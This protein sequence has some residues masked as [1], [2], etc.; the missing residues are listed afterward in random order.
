MIVN[1]AYPFMGEKGPSVNPYLWQDGV[2]NYPVQFTR[3]NISI[4]GLKINSN[5]GSATFSEMT[6]TK[7]TSLTITGEGSANM[8]SVAVN[9]EFYSDDALIGKETVNFSKSGNTRNV[10]IPISAR[11]KNAKIKMSNKSSYNVTMS[12]A[13]LN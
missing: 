2:S 10:N 3:A 7:F 8:G 5:G 13:V 9:I 12:E 1:T 11:V 4:E 6:L